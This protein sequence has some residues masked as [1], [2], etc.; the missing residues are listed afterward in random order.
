MA[1]VTDAN[2]AYI[3][4]RLDEVAVEEDL[5]LNRCLAQGGGQDAWL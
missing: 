4:R 2:A 1:K 3:A 5:A